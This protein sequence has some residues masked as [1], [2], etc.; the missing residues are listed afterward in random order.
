MIVLRQFELQTN[1]LYLNYLLIYFIIILTVVLLI[2]LMVPFHV[3]I[4]RIGLYVGYIEIFQAQE[5][6]YVDYTCIS[7]AL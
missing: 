2:S 7:N 6:H 3:R 1:I 4:L 5:I